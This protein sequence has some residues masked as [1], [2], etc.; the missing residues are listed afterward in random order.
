V[1]FYRNQ[2]IEE[3]AA[4]RLAQLAGVL[5]RQLTPPI[6]ID[7][8]AEKVLRLVLHHSEFDG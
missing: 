4:E 5:G 7:L 8:L 3:L 1:K 2:E 6:P